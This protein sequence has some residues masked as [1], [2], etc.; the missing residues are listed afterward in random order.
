MQGRILTLLAVALLSGCDT[1]K[2][3]SHS[4]NDLPV[5][6][7]DTLETKPSP[8]K[9]VVYEAS[10]TRINDILHTKIEISFDY[11]KQY[12]YGKATL[13]LKP[14]FYPTNTLSLDARGMDIKKVELKKDSMVV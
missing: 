7:L 14:Y 10:A 4:D 11:V 13:T 8:P 2:K 3:A 6:H 5:V 1:T 9:S 12:A